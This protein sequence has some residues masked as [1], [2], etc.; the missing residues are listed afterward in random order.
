MMFYK[1]ISNIFLPFFPWNKKVFSLFL[2]RIQKYRIFIARESYWLIALLEMPE[3]VTFSVHICVMGCGWTNYY[4]VFREIMTS[5]PVTKQPPVSASSVEAATNFKN[6]QFTYT[7]PFT[8]SC[9]SFDWAIPNNK[10]PAAWLR[11]FVSARYDTSVLARK[12]MSGAWNQTT[13]SGWV[14]M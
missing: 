3:A 6:L 4:N 11:T 13:A 8:E 12:I 9:I 14:A 7:W 5:L 1:I 10:Y 2:S